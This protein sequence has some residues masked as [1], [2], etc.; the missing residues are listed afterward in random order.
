MR[1]IVSGCDRITGAVACSLVRSAIRDSGWMADISEVVHAGNNG[2]DRAA[3]DVAAGR[4]PCRSFS[5]HDGARGTVAERMTAYADALILVWD[6]VSPGSASMKREAELRG[7]LVFEVVA[8]GRLSDT[9]VDHSEPPTSR[10]RPA[11][12]TRANARDLATVAR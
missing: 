8:C 11:T 3:A 7:L 9:P 2:I 4:W 10:T 6:G 5:Q 12:A 1:V